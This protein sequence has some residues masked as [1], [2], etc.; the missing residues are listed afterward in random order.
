MNRP[1]K[2]H[3]TVPSSCPYCDYRLDSASN[4][5]DHDE[6]GP[7]PGDWTICISCAQPLVFDE[8][9]I[10][11]KPRAGEA[12][13][14]DAALKAKLELLARAVR[15]VDRRPPWEKAGQPRPLNRQQR[16]AQQRK[17]YSP[18]PRGR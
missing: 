3:R 9:I 16:R 12:E 8:N 11:R 17:R 1:S 4:I 15:T 6:A 13:A 5:L 18:V 14:M 10:V 7:K 2:R